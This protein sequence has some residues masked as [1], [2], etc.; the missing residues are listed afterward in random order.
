MSAADH[1]S[2]QAAGYARHRPTYPQELF[3][4]LVGQSAGRQ[5]A[6]DC[7]TGNGQA[8]VA[9]AEHFDQVWAT[10]LSAAQIA[11][12]SP[13]PRI[14]YRTAEATSS[15][16]DA[17]S[18]DLVSVAQALHWFCH[19]DFYAEVERVL[20]PG[21]LLAAWTYTLL[22]VDPAIDACIGRFYTAVI[23]PYWPAERRW[24]DLGYAGMPFPYP[25]IPAPAFEIRLEWTLADLLDY[26][27]TWSAS[28]AYLRQHGSDPTQAVA[29][30]LAAAWG[31]AEQARTVTWPLRL[32][33]GR[34][35]A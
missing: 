11:Q 33:C 3:A 18:C 13:H 23:G 17:A 34:K 9:L 32:R 12:A 6:W 14:H 20:K 35:P 16:L 27:R 2:A 7:A 19:E 29:A 31:A 15:G 1:F 30:E 5:L 22:R 25:D 26:L 28:Q 24:V 4:W 10:D 8:A 21:G